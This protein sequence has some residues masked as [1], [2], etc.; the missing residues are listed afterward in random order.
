MSLILTTPALFIV[1][2]YL[3]RKI[4]GIKGFQFLTQSS[5]FLYAG[6]FLFC[7]MLLHAIGPLL[8][9]VEFMGK[10]TLLVT[11]FVIGGCSL[12]L[13]FYAIAKRLFGRLLAPWDGTL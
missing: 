4:S 10:E 6:H 12:L 2:F 7:S 11:I 3:G 1:V 13:G 5:F 9:G 8:N